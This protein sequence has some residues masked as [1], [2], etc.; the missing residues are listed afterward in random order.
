[1]SAEAPEIRDELDEYLAEQDA[2]PRLRGMVA[3]DLRRQ[4]GQAP[5]QRSRV[6]AKAKSAPKEEP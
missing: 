6:P 3:L 2:R 1:M 4:A 5:Y